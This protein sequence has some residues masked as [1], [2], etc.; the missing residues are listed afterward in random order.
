MY[1]LAYI[2]TFGLDVGPQDIS[3]I[4][5]RSRANNKRKGITGLLIAD[6]IRFLQIL[7][8]ERLDV[9]ETF[10]R[11][12]KDTRHFGVF[13]LAE[14]EIVSRGFGAWDMAYREVRGSTDEDD[15]ARQAEL[16]ANGLPAGEMRSKLH[17]FLRLDRG[18]I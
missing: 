11:I 14:S 16:M 8:G 7:E 3:Q 2:S 6:G 5:E 4:L 13:K 12:G 10:T 1:Q 18:I 17:Y 15:L 9:E